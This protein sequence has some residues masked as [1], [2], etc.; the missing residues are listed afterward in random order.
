METKREG[1]RST[2]PVVFTSGCGGEGLHRRGAGSWVLVKFESQQ[3]H[4][5]S[6]MGTCRLKECW[7]HRPEAV[8][9]YDSVG[10]Y[11]LLTRVWRHGAISA[12]IPFYSS[13]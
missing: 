9:P 1:D 5:Q 7:L 2:G 8:L 11:F 10:I 6:D 4:T 13:A 12:E 3:G